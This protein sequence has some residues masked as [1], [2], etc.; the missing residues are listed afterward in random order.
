MAAGARLGSGGQGSALAGR[1]SERRWQSRAVP[2]LVTE[3]APEG[4]HLPSLSGHLLCEL[5][6]LLF[7]GLFL[8]QEKPLRNLTVHSPQ[9]GWHRRQPGRAAG[10]VAPA[11]CRTRWKIP[12]LLGTAAHAEVPGVQTGQ[13]LLLLGSLPAAGSHSPGELRGSC[14][15]LLPAPGTASC[16]LGSAPSQ[17]PFSTGA[18]RGSDT[19]REA[20]GRAE[21][22]PWPLCQL[23][24]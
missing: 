24:T 19:K 7:Q 23:W 16:A 17:P 5:S 8:T 9:L 13:G 6:D 2:Q 10:T 15:Q 22:Q 3:T 12:L 21:Q 18:G 4:R 14:A 11:A 1:S 20:P